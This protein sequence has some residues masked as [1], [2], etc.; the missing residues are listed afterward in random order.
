LL[1]EDHRQTNTDVDR[2]RGDQ[3]A[4][5]ADPLNQRE[6]GEQHADGRAKAVR[7]VEQPERLPR[8]VT[9]EAKRAGAHQRKRRAKQDRLRQNQE[10]GQPPLGDRQTRAARQRREDVLVRDAGDHAIHV[11]EQ[12][13]DHA[14]GE[15]DVRVRPQR[16]LH[17]FGA[18][19]D[20][21]RA[22]RHPAEEDDEHD[23]LRVGAVADE[24]PEI[25]TPDG[26][27][28]QS[29]GAGKD[30]D[31]RQESHWRAKRDGGVL[32][33]VGRAGRVAGTL[34][35]SPHLASL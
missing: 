27:V 35:A 34:P 25:P 9:T 15:L 6:A 12:H 29:R 4:G 32:A 28:D 16:A 21:I 19:P 1:G 3:R 2:G 18:L 33:E 17:T 23:D 8:T 22:G 11:V 14:R 26:L 10:A 13:P 31:E 7:E 5:K 24:Q 20:E 30:E